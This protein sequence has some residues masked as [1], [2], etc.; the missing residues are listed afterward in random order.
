MTGQ[1]KLNSEH[2]LI[3]YVG[4]QQFS[5]SIQHPILSVVVGSYKPIISINHTNILLL[6]L[7]VY[8]MQC[9][10]SLCVGGR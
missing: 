2:Y 1:A 4:D 9:F 7:F 5:Y 10:V 3:K 6:L 8:T